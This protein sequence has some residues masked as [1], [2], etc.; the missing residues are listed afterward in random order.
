MTCPV[1]A[2]IHSL[3]ESQTEDLGRRL[4]ALVRAGDTVTLSGDLGAGKTTFARAM[5]QTLCGV[6]QEVPS[7]TFTLVQVYE[8]EDLLEIWHVDL[9][10]LDDREEI[11]ELG[12]NDALECALVLIEWP[13]RAGE[14]LTSKR[15]EIEI[16]FCDKPEER[17]LEFKGGSEWAR[18]LVGYLEVETR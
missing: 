6:E 5:I 4:S 13:E 1:V 16:R 10:R 7:P 11:Y 8:A 14:Y 9:Y 15:L 18:R 17:S 3:C 2:S 12:L